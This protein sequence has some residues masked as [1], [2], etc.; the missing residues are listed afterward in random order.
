MKAIRIAAAIILAA[1]I[2]TAG[3]R[4]AQDYITVTIKQGD[5]LTGIAQQYLKNPARW[6]EIAKYNNIPEPYHLKP[7]MTVK[8]PKSLLKATPANSPATPDPAP[9]SSP[10]P[11]PAPAPHNPST[12][13]PSPMPTTPLSGRAA[14]A[15]VAYVRGDV[16]RIPEKGTEEHLKS[17]AKLL[18][19]DRLVTDATSFTAIS[20]PV[21]SELNVGSDTRLK[22][23]VIEENQP[24]NNGKVT[25]QLEQGRIRIR[26]PKRGMNLNLKASSVSV[27]AGEG[28]FQFH[29][30]DSGTFYL[31]VYKGKA[32]VSS[33]GNSV[34]VNSG[35]GIVI[36]KDAPLR[37]KAF[38]P[39]PALK[40]YSYSSDEGPKAGV[41]W[42]QSEQASSYRIEIAED[43]KFIK[44]IYIA[45]YAGATLDFAFFAQFPPGK[46]AFRLIAVSAD[47]LWGPPSN[48][49]VYNQ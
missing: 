49:M 46:Y 30:D 8:I 5:T 1:L 4:A 47:G 32:V 26:D 3:I 23:E 10:A 48:A 39:A 16:V 31:E 40:A 19:G 44:T 43:E 25:I 33:E 12:P 34:T 11:T 13:S 22:F 6:Q 38:P 2:M 14:K 27:S 7:G 36:S 37:P 20:L 29:I 9:T 18:T 28:E 35:N 24:V 15:Y 42:D 17:N 41:M 21:G 45:G